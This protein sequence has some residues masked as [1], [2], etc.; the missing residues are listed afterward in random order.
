MTNAVLSN[1]DWR[2]KKPVSCRESCSVKQFLLTWGLQE[3]HKPTDIINSWYVSI[4]GQ[5]VKW[6]SSNSQRSLQSSV[7]WL[8]YKYHTYVH[9][10]QKYHC[11]C[12]S[13]SKSCPTLCNPRDCSTSGFPILHYLPEFAQ[14]HVHWVCD[15][16][17]FIL[18]RPLLLLSSVFPSIRVF[19]NESVLDGGQSIGVSASASVLPMN[20]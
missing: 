1:H 16:I 3:V 4:W 6:L 9:N 8:R 7:Y 17:L 11:C 20:V 14:T 19:S 2:M 18:C 10:Y 13:L 15:A 5:Q 12:C